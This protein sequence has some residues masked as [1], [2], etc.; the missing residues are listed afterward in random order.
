MFAFIDNHLLDYR[1]GGQVALWQNAQVIFQMRTHQLFGG[2]DKT[3][4]DAVAY[5]TG[6]G[7]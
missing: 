2:G 4:A 6:S 3:Q 1:L 7:T 5:Q